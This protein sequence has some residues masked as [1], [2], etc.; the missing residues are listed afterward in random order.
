MDKVEFLL[1]SPFAAIDDSK[2]DMF[3]LGN[4]SESLSEPRDACDADGRPVHVI[5]P[6]F[7][8][9]GNILSLNRVEVLEQP[10]AAVSK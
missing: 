7:A 3:V 5:D 8:V 1:K 6:K 9:E 2:S 4:R 10:H